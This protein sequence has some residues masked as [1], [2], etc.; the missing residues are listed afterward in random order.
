MRGGEVEGRGVPHTPC[1]SGKTRTGIGLAPT[2]HPDFQDSEL[3]AVTNYSPDRHLK[4]PRTQ[5]NKLSSL[6]QRSGKM[7]K[8]G[9]GGIAFMLRAR[10]CTGMV[11]GSTMKMVEWRGSLWPTTCNSTLQDGGASASHASPESK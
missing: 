3:P 6:L 11:R 1:A 7:Y 8:W 2:S 5:E 9:G 10:N 4:R